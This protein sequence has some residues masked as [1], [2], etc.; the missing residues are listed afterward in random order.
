[1]PAS[2]PENHR[3]WY[4]EPWVWLLIALPLSAVIGGLTTIYIAVSTS[5]GLVVDDYYRRGKEINR[6]LDRD[7]AAA[8][9]G[10]EAHLRVE[11]AAR[12]VTLQLSAQDYTL[13][14]SL[15]FAFLHPTREG[16]DQHLMLPSIG[17]G[18]YGGVI[19]ALPRG[20]WY[21][22]LEADDWRLQGSVQI[23]QEETLILVPSVPGDS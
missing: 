5:D 23:P 7:H 8:T 14:Q 11:A 12:R 16:F 3:P 17:E 6:D 21:V 19:D 10:L 15:R 22:Q 9:H 18:R 20:N 13:P 1:M 2:P 4:A